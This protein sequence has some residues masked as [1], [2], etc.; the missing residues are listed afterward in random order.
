[1]QSLFRIS[2][3][4]KDSYVGVGLPHGLASV[5]RSGTVIVELLLDVVSSDFLIPH[6]SITTK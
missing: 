6:A 4:Y 1:M 3:L 2:T 5:D